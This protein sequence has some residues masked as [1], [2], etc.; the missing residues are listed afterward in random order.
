M[1]LLLFFVAVITCAYLVFTLIEFIIGFG[2]IKNL[3]LQ[4]VLDNRH[5]PSI[6]IILSLLNEEHNIENVITSLMSLDYPDFEVVAVNDRSTDKTAAILNMLAQKYPRLRVHNIE[7]LPEGW[8]GKNHG[9]H[10]GSSF[11]RGQWLLFTDAD[12]TM[13]KDALLKMVSFAIENKLDHLTIHERHYH[14]RFWMKSMLLAVYVSY[15]MVVKPWRVKYAWSKRSVGRGACNLVNKKSYQQC[16]GHQA[17]ALECLDDLKLGELLKKS[18]LRQDVADAYD[19]VEFKWYTSLREV[20]A[21]LEKNSFAFFNYNAVVASLVSMATLLFY[22]WPI[23][24]VFACSGVLQELNFLN[25]ILTFSLT[26]IVAKHYRLKK[27][28]ALFYA[29]GICILLYTIW[30]SMT[31][32]Y[33]NK[34][35]IWRG[36]HYPLAILRNQK[37]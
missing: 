14:G 21:G 12:V 17:I 30:K 4:P 37:I 24:A 5:L 16:G 36:T 15:S 23:I 31:A 32:T 13:Q 29:F 34:G 10:V 26:A 27:F 1:E 11:A 20:V 18:K 3:T 22:I 7:S 8:F 35:V 28:Y 25:I 6:S 19:L 33:K 2:K 9:L